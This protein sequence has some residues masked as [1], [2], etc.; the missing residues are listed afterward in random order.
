[1]YFGSTFYKTRDTTNYDFNHENVDKHRNW[2]CLFILLVIIF[3]IKNEIML[4]N[5]DAN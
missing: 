3:V 1:L 2:L 5:F 4:I